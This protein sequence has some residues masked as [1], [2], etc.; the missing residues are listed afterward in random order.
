MVARQP[1]L[2]VYRVDEIAETATC[3][4]LAI[5][6]VTMDGS[7]ASGIAVFPDPE[8]TPVFGLPTRSKELQCEGLAFQSAEDLISWGKLADAG[9]AGRPA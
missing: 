6:V 4:A 7:A 9:E 1:S 2:A 5:V 3:R 8:L